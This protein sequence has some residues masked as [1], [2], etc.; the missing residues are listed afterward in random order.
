MATHTRGGGGD[1]TVEYPQIIDRPVR[2]VFRFVA[3]R[4]VENHPRWDPDV[5]LE[6]DADEPLGVGS[7]IRRRNT[8]YEEPVEG[9]ME[10]VEYVPDE[11]MGAVI[12]EGGFEMS[13]RIT[14]EELGPETT[15]MTRIAV[16]PDTLDEG[17]IRQQMEQTSRTIRTLVESES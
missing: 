15:R 6:Y 7:V 12:R 16:V 1:V 17:L 14:F 8:R 4:H 11:A 10:I 5:E 9:T 3:E 2:D 13:G